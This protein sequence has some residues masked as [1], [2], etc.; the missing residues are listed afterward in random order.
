MTFILEGSQIIDDIGSQ[1]FNIAVVIIG[2]AVG[3]K[4]IADD[5]IL[6]G[7]DVPL[8]V[9]RNVEV[10]IAG[11][12]SVGRQIFNSADSKSIAYPLK[13]SQFDGI[14]GLFH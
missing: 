3:V 10:E 9:G 7:D 11:Y 2:G 14:E 1:L 13:R 4:F 8:E 5:R 6:Q 12:I